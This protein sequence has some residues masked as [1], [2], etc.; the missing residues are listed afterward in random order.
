VWLNYL[1]RVGKGI[2]LRVGIA[3]GA[4]VDLVEHCPGE[5]DCELMIGK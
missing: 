4:L 3:M 1:A 2:D 5:G